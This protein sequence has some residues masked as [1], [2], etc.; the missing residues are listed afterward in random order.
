MNSEA[1]DQLYADVDAAITL[2]RA[3]SLSSRVALLA[4]IESFPI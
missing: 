2:F 3:S 1:R 4:I